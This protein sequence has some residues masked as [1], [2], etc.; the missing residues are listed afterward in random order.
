MN[1][2]LKTFFAAA[3]AVASTAGALAQQ[4][5]VTVPF[6]ADD[7]GAMAY[8]VNYD[9]SAKI[10]SVTVDG[11]KAVF[12]GTI[13][14][15]ALARIIMDGA[16]KG[17]FILEEGTIT[18]DP[19]TRTVQGGQLNAAS[20]EFGNRIKELV[21]PYKTASAAEKSII[22]NKYNALVDSMM[23]ANINNPIGYQL[24][25]ERAYEMTP[26]Q[27]EEAVAATPALQQYT[28]VQKLLQANKNLAATSQ[29]NMF[30]DFEIEYNGQKHRLSDV[31]G[32]GKPVLVDFWASWCGPCR[33]E[34]PNLKALNE[35]Y[36]PKGL[37]IL[38][39][40]VWDEP[41][42][43]A[44]AVKEMELPWEIW[45]NGQNVPTDVYG[46]SGIPTLILFGPDGRIL[47]RGLQ[48]E[49][50]TKAV[51]AYMDVLQ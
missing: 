26:A 12:S 34:M 28:R 8:L 35:K 11:G 39:V 37:K 2:T 3:V 32:K 27:L 6:G 16:R 19:A 4:Y 31:V 47:S 18:V 25:L 20:Q 7:D 51:S 38:G 48:G 42:N 5:T 40:A 43:T 44:Q 13:A 30:A 24:F 50:L 1:T 49:E 21:A 14:S 10:D 9:T 33:R 29:G 46:I 23:Q 45:Y 15:P 17:Q 36:G 41:A 22:E